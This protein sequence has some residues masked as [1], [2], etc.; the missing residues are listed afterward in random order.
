MSVFKENQPRT[1]LPQPGELTM[2]PE[3]LLSLIGDPAQVAHAL[4]KFQ[5]KARDYDPLPNAKLIL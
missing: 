3:Q 1:E 4:S 5:K 2:T